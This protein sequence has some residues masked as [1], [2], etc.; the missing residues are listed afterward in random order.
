MKNIRYT[1]YE[2]ICV[3]VRKNQMLFNVDG[4]TIHQVGEGTWWSMNE[5]GRVHNFIRP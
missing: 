4:I 3:K 5:I 2:T 1:I